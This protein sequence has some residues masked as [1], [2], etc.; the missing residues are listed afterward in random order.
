M[1]IRRAVVADVPPIRHLL[2]ELWGWKEAI[3]NR[4]VAYDASTLPALLALLGDEIVGLA[5]LSFADDGCEVVTLN[6]TPRGT[7][8]GTALLSAAADTAARAGCRRLWLVTTNDQPR[9]DP[10]LPAQ[11]DAVGR[12]PCRSR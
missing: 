10:L 7:G 5:T 3:V 12:G 11:G 9:C 1:V 6:A 8:I 2:Q 4:G